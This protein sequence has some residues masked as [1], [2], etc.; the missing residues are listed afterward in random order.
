PTEANLLGG[1][2]YTFAYDAHGLL[3]ADSL[4]SA[5]LELGRYTYDA[6]RKLRQVSR[7]GRN[8]LA[9][10]YDAAG[11]LLSV[12]SATIDTRMT[13]Q[14]GT[15][16]L[17]SV[18]AGTGATGQAYAL[19][20]DGRLPTSITA[21]G[22]VN[23]RVDYTY[24]PDLWLKSVAIAGRS[25]ITYDYDADGL[26]TRG[27]ALTLK[28]DLVTG[29]ITG[30]TIGVV[31][32]SRTYDEH[33]ALSG[34]E[35]RI[36]GTPTWSQRL[37]RDSIGRITVQR[38]SDATSGV[39]VTGY[40]YDAQDRLDLV[41]KDGAAAQAFTFD[42]AGNRTA[43]TTSA[44][45]VAATYAADDRILSFDGQAIRHDAS[46]S[47]ASEVRGA[48]TL[49]YQY[50]DLGRVTQLT[51]TTAGALTF[52]YDAQGRRVQELRG[53]TVVRSFLY[54]ALTGPTAELTAA[55]TVKSEFVQVSGYMAPDY[56]VQ[57][58]TTYYVARDQ[59]GNVRQV[60]DVASGTVAQ[61]V[62]YDVNGVVTRNTKSGFQPFGYAG[63]QNDAN[64]RTVHFGARDYDP[65]TGRWVQPDP[66]GAGGGQNRYAYVGNDQIGRLDPD[67]LCFEDLCIMEIYAAYRGASTLYGLYRSAQFLEQLLA[68]AAANLR[69]L[70]SRKGGKL[71][72]DDSAKGPHSTF[73]TN[74]DDSEITKWQNWSPRKDPR[75]P[76]KWEPGD[77][78]DR[79]GAPHYNNKTGEDVPT[80]HVRSKNIR[81]GVCSLPD[82]WTLFGRD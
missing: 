43:V 40:R 29:A 14:P 66:I 3:T 46:G 60:I 41:T 36:A 9:L 10:S 48:D 4:A 22:L 18:S 50:D 24:T 52:T 23:G 70:E 45:I 17:T 55:G 59:L 82:Y 51:S 77:R 21:S 71:Q 58:T 68:P 31:A 75:N 7:P 32:T 79:Y 1:R 67:G 63:G 49:G 33:G 12:A 42:A 28:R 30:D 61:A 8:L 27:G 74:A 81:G 72:P 37:T 26:V 38:D 15:G 64:G 57:G 73:K 20:Y 65:R 53:G 19:Q 78:F 54:G 11:R 44:G 35:L 69:A 80:P 76:N 56:L 13:Y 62:D 34:I 39:V 6:G 5:G 25:P 16:L 47:R 2:R